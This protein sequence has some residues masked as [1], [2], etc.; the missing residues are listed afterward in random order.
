MALEDFRGGMFAAADTIDEVAH[1]GRF[2]R[3]RR[4][5]VDR[6][7]VSLPLGIAVTEHAFVGV[8]LDRDLPTILVDEARL[9]GLPKSS[10]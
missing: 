7:A 2:G 3:R 8:V 10:R 5:V 6:H 9:V 4:T 1:M